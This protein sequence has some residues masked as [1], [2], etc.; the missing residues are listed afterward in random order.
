VALAFNVPFACMA[1]HR[2]AFDT[3]VHVFL[4]DHYRK[5]WWEVWDGRWYAGFST[6]SYPPLAHQTVALGSWAIEGVRRLGPGG[7][8]SSSDERRLVAED[9]GFVALLMA[10]L[11]AFPL[12]ARE[13]GRVFVGRRAAAAGALCA[14]LVP[15]IALSSWSFGQLPTICALVL[16]LFAAA[17]G[18]RFLRTGCRVAAAESVSW[19]AVAAVTHHGSLLL[20]PWLGVAVAWRA[21]AQRHGRPRSGGRA[22]VL[23]RIVTLSGACWAAMAAA[24]WPFI[25]WWWSHTLQTPIDHGSRHDFLLD[26]GARSWFFWPVYGPLL[27]LIPALLTSALRGSRF[28]A[29]AAVFSVLFV[30]GLGGTTSAPWWFFGAGANWL[31]YDRFALWAAVLLAPFFGA[32]ALRAA[33]GARGVPARWSRPFAVVLVATAMLSGWSSVYRKAQPAAL[34]MNEIAR[35]LREP[36]R[37]SYRFVT[38]GFGDQMAKLSVLVDNGS[39]DGNY[40]TARELPALRTSGLGSLDGAVW[41]PFGA[42][43]LLPYL[44]LARKLGT[45]WALVAHSAYRPVLVAGGWTYHSS[46]SGVEIWEHPRAEHARPVTPPSQTATSIWLGIVPICCLIG[47]CGVSLGRSRCARPAIG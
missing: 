10:A 2:R 22:L 15:G 34:D 38:L 14:C 6:A 36:S 29:L 1:V 12:A 39:I 37:A 43:G 30:L 47:A 44:D 45:R 19:F 23:R 16:I 33:R 46:V 13:F 3:D 20:L 41:S 7:A 18:H 26:G 9:A 8:P 11:A 17:R 35:F 24:S 32:A 5:S 27:L 31:T 21:L 25:A 42:R 28:R 40:H 4:A